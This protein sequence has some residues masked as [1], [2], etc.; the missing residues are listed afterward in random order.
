MQAY[1]DRGYQLFL[2]RVADGRRMKVA[3]VDSIAQGRVW[4]GS[5]ALKIKLVDKLGT[6]DDAVARAAQLG[7]V[8]NYC[9]ASYPAKTDWLENILSSYKDDYMEQQLRSALGVYYQ[10]LRFV[11]GLKG[12]DCLQARI[13]FEPNIR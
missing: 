13:P 5:Q 2:K 12:T 4:T 11:K 10:P 3:E 9:L 6:L 8:K 1:V 7:K